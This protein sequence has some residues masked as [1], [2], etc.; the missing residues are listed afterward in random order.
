MTQWIKD[1]VLSLLW[2]MFSLW[3]GNF[4]LGAV[5]HPKKEQTRV[6]VRC[7]CTVPALELEEGPLF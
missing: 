1:L 5:L 4:C 6:T 7:H 2:L 3:P